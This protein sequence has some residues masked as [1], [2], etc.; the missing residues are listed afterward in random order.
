[1]LLLAERQRTDQGQAAT[2]HASAYAHSAPSLPWGLRHVGC[3]SDQTTSISRATRTRDVRGGASRSLLD[4]NSWGRLMIS[5]YIW[6]FRCKKDAWGHASMLVGRT[7]ISWWPEKPGQVP[8]KIVRNIYASGPFRNRSFDEDCRDEGQKPD[9]KI[10]LHGLDESAIKDWW[11]FF[12]LTRDG[13]LYQGPLQAWETLNMNCSTVVAHGLTIGGG[14]TYS[15]L[16]KSW[17]VVWTPRDVLRYARAIE[18]GLLENTPLKIS[19]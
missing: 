4:D 6:N 5:V 8:S 2:T 12:G 3:A 18:V 15:G 1:M 13:V 19:K 7:Y 10:N 14:R 17:N 16:L 11:Q 9:H